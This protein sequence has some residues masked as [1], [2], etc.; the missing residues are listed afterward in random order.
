MHELNTTLS[1]EDCYDLIEIAVIDA[2]NAKLI[3]AANEGK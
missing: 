3:K 2:H 1:V